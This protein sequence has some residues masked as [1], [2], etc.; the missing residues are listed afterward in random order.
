M[1]MPNEKKTLCRVMRLQLHEIVKLLLQIGTF[2][3]KIKLPF[4]FFTITLNNFVL[5]DEFTD[6]ISTNRFTIS[7]I[8]IGRFW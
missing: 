3:S 7:F 6:L 1:R 5:S 8:L 4:E 2:R